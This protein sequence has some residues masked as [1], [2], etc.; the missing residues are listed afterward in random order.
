[1]TGG[2][3][4]FIVRQTAGDFFG[5]GFFRIEDR[6]LRHIGKTSAR[7]DKAGAGIQFDQPGERLQQ[8]G[9]AAAIASHKADSLTARDRDRGVDESGAAAESDRGVA[10]SRQ[11]RQGH[12]TGPVS[13]VGVS[14]R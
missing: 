3:E 7:L 9:F 12:Y 14:R 2:G 6:L 11:G 4:G 10:Q 13:A 5:G 8:G 1:M